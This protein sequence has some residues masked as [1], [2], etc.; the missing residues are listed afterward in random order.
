MRRHLIPLC[1]AGAVV[2]FA[3]C[4]AWGFALS[5]IFATAVAYSVARAVAQKESSK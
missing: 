2:A 1:I 4:D 3:A 5:T